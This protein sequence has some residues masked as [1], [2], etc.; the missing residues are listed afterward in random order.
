MNIISLESSI[1]A[2]PG[3][4]SA[5]PASAAGA[6]LPD[7]TSTTT[8]QAQSLP[9]TIVNL[10]G[11]SSA[12]GAK[13]DIYQQPTVYVT[14][15]RYQLATTPLT[16]SIN[17]QLLSGANSI[18]AKNTS[19][20]VSGL[21]G[22]LGNLSRETTEY[23]N[24]ARS[25][26]V[27]SDKAEKL[28]ID[29]S[30]AKGRLLN[31][32]NL[33]IRTKDGD[34]I[35]IRAEHAHGKG[36]SIAFS[37]VVTGELSPEEQDA[38]EKLAATLGEV[39]DDFFRTGTTQLRGL[40]EFDKEQLQGF[41]LDFIRPEGDDYVTMNFD[42]SVD[43]AAQTQQLT[44]KDVDGYKVDIK[45][46]LNGLLE[47]AGAAANNSFQ[48][49]L[50]VLSESLN[51]HELSTVSRLFILDSFSSMLMPSGAGQAQP[52]SSTAEAALSA[53]DSGLADFSVTIS[54]PLH[55]DHTNYLYP[56]S[57]T[58]KL[59]QKTE[60][61]QVEQRTLVK[62]VNSYEFTSSRIDGIVGVD[63]G[64]LE[65]GNFNYKTTH[66]KEQLS[67]LLDMTAEGVNNLYS[68]YEQSVDIKEQVYI[69]FKLQDTQ[70][71]DK[72]EHMV[73]QLLDTDAA[74]P[75]EKDSDEL[76]DKV[77]DSRQSLFGFHF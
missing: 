54:S 29:F 21:F 60:V 34:T 7:D 63:D 44:A 39:A 20:S 13:K 10:S 41:R 55:Q 71:Q 24:E 4:R 45:T 53:F 66:I 25:V 58:L 37:F 28:G 77:A 70:R 48:E 14:Q 17:S 64:D 57:M 47:N 40:K 59:E 16:S 30:T 15:T 69:A 3:N 18:S 62:Q 72:Q 49:Y 56:D 42:Y 36:D 27:A 76:L 22:Q 26:L 8:P 33:T 5:Q 46:D 12:A 23:R 2:L 9:A 31:S 35:D 65:S 68:E 51:K 52:P 74:T 32:V 1:P 6:L 73:K 43:E 67:R 61:E 38:L 19:F 11:A 50:S 75:P